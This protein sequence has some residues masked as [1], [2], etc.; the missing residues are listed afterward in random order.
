VRSEPFS[1]HYSGVTDG[2]DG[3]TRAMMSVHPRQL[4]IFRWTLLGGSGGYD[5]FRG[6]STLAGLTSPHPPI[7]LGGLATW[8]GWRFPCGVLKMLR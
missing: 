5:T 1:M 7:E 6:S 2:I 8:R 3:K 4:A